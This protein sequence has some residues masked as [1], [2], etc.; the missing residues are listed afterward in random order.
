MT[1]RNEIDTDLWE[2]IQKNYESENYT[3]AILDAIFKLTDVIRNKTGLEGDGASL[4][5]QAFGGDNPRIKLNK[6]QTD[7]EKDIQRGIQEILRGIYTGIRNPRSHDTMK[8]NQSTCDSIIVFINYLLQMID[9]SKLS[10]DEN[11]YL[12]RVFDPYYVKTKEYSDLLVQEIPKRQRANI[13]VQV[14]LQRSSGDIYVLG[15]FFESLL[16]Q[17]ESS[18]L[19]RVFKV[20]DDELRITQNEEDIRYLVN[21]CPGE[22]WNHIEET[23]R[24]RT[25][26]ILYNDFSKG[27]YYEETEEW[28]EY[29]ALATWITETHFEN[30]EE[31]EKWTRQ[32]VDMIQSQNENVVSYVDTYFWRMVCQVNRNNIAWSLK[33]YFQKGLKDNDQQ[34]IERLKDVI[35]WDEDHPWWYVFEEELKEYPEIKYDKDKLPF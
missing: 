5:G 10:F 14:I 17:L 19:S 33:R 29:G 8:D 25:E 32:A 12:K 2:A 20:I 11:E 34:V 13:A 9:K 30:F 22:Y 28:G 21:M 23:V 4:I 35:E 1:I 31:L 18:E 16:K 15:L 26:A 27:S 6:L 3:G 7:S 24:M